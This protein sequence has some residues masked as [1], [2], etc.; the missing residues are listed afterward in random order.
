MFAFSFRLFRPACVLHWGNAERNDALLAASRGWGWSGE[1]VSFTRRVCVRCD[2]A[3]QRRGD[4]RGRPSARRAGDRCRPDRRLGDS[5]AQPAETPANA[6]LFITVRRSDAIRPI[7]RRV[8]PSDGFRCRLPETFLLCVCVCVCVC[9]TALSKVRAIELNPRRARA[10][11]DSRRVVLISFCFSS[12]SSSEQVYRG[13]NITN[14]VE[15]G[16][17]VK[18]DNWCKT[19]HGRKCKTVQSVKPYRCLG[20]SRRLHHLPVQGPL[21]RAAPLRPA[22]MW[23]PAKI[24][25]PFLFNP[26]AL[27][28]GDSAASVFF[29][30]KFSLLLSFF[31]S[32][33]PHPAKV[34]ALLCSCPNLGDLLLR[35][36]LVM[37]RP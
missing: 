28:P 26:P 18:I 14:I 5:V 16:R 3:D 32:P 23:R 15:A 17:T 34:S 29:S 2:Q 31:L 20:E 37:R 12:S 7:R 22:A 11:S 25:Q 6:Q 30:P 33:L 35:F 8:L 24:R 10:G 13:R 9:W 1:G 27:A 19:G 36:Q 21:R 4:A